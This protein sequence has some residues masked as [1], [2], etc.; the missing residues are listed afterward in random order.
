M[1]AHGR[2]SAAD[3]GPSREKAGNVGTLAAFD[4][5]W[6]YRALPPTPHNVLRATRAAMAGRRSA[7]GRIGAIARFL[8]WVIKV[9]RHALGCVWRCGR[10]ARRHGAPSA[11][12]QFLD[13][14]KLAARY[15]IE[16]KDYHPSALF[17]VSTDAFPAIVPYALYASVASQLTHQRCQ[18]VARLVINKR[19]LAE[20][21]AARGLPAIPTLAHVPQS[22][23]AP[24]KLPQTDLIVKP[25][26]GKQGQGIERW[27][28]EGSSY[29][30]RDGQSLSED[31]L[32]ERLTRL[33][34]R[35]REGI[36]LQPCLVNH[37]ALAAFS[38]SAFSTTR[39]C[40]MLSETGEPEIVEAFL[41]VSVEPGAVVDNF[42]AGG[43]LFP[44]DL[45]CGELLPAVPKDALSEAPAG[46]AG[47]PMPPRHP[48]FEAVSS[49]ALRSHR[50]FPS[51]LIV[52]WDIGVTAD[53]AVLVEANVPPGI[54]LPQQLASGHYADSRL[55]ELLAWHAQRWADGALPAGSR[56]R[57][58]A[59]L[60][61][62]CA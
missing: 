43:A 39:V 30:G 31:L 26:R 17:R 42:H 13:M 45:R 49:L 24:D 14:L 19:L 2:S 58:G 11:A 47:P 38:G 54:T 62:L 3:C 56:W 16:P 51:L 20:A 40:T 22:G 23:S 57:V 5:W 8:E 32:R 53:G 50:A 12:R 10:M 46:A 37:P 59:D 15:S 36:L 29:V 18:E 44:I 4:L 55:I 41:R 35:N 6:N 60:Q 28:W 7:L 25:V 27:R 48:A 1:R 52:G 21:A 34:R 61:P 9:P 33:A